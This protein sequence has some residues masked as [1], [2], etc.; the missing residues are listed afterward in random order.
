MRYLAKHNVPKIVWQTIDIAKKEFGDNAFV[1]IKGFIAGIIAM[2][3][4][5]K[6]LEEFPIGDFVLVKDAPQ[7]SAK[8]KRVIV[9]DETD[10]EEDGIEALDDTESDTNSEVGVEEENFYMIT[11]GELK[12]SIFRMNDVTRRTI[13]WLYSLD[14]ILRCTKTTKIKKDVVKLS[15]E[16]DAHKLKFLSTHDQSE[17]EYEL[18][19]IVD[20]SASIYIGA[21]AKNAP[22]DAEYLVRAIYDVDNDT[23]IDL[24]PDEFRFRELGQT[25]LKRGCQHRCTSKTENQIFE[26]LSDG[27]ATF[28]KLGKGYVDNCDICGTEKVITW[29]SESQESKTSLLMGKTCY[30]YVKLAHE[31]FN[32]KKL[33]LDLDELLTRYRALMPHNG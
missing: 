9:N 6:H 8:R 7:P 11:N 22:P 21:L 32:H 16:K 2:D 5:L 19:D 10:D 13:T 23:I 18:C 1:Y 14:D 17:F 4:T 25:L 26:H 28:T 30:N 20:I 33:Q 31:F 29:K 3:T 27:N 12:G 15:Q 24:D